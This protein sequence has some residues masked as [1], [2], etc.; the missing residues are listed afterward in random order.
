MQECT[1]G[2][3][4]YPVLGLVPVYV[5]SATSKYEGDVKLAG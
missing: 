4:S 2:T 1:S 5:D 3:G